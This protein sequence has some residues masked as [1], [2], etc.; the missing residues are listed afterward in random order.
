MNYASITIVGTPSV[1]MNVNL[2]RGQDMYIVRN[3]KELLSALTTRRSSTP[4]Q[5]A[6][7]AQA[8]LSN[9]EPRMLPFEGEIHATTVSQRVTMEQNLRKA[10][11]LSSSQDFDVDDGY[12]LLIIDDED[13]NQKQ[14]YAKVVD[15]PE[16]SQYGR[17]A[18]SVFRFQMIAE[19]DVFLYDTTLTTIEGIE[20][21]QATTFTLQDGTLQ[22]FKDGDL[23]TFQ[24]TGGNE[25]TV[26]N[27]G[28]QDTPPVITITGPTTNP[29]LTNVTT[30]RKMAFN[31]GDGVTLLEGESL[32]VT[33][34]PTS[35]TI[36][37]TDVLGVETDVSSAL[38]DDSDLIYIAPGNNVLIFSDDTSD[39]LEGTITIGFR[40]CWA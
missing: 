38:S 31:K 13:G 10:L 36:I 32:T 19:E 28:T 4:K 33:I 14:I 11:T 25:M 29:S 20:S 34:N 30:G 40:N 24:D 23:P 5:G 39:L 37:K 7:G 18:S 22:T 1:Q 21:Y 9:F 26:T 12:R 6:H 8:G 2:H 16:F 27:N 35:T 3:T 17:S 15:M